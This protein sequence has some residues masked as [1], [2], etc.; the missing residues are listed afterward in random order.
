MTGSEE[1]VVARAHVANTRESSQ[2]NPLWQRKTILRLGCEHVSIEIRTCCIST[3]LVAGSVDA[4]L[5]ERRV[6]R[7]IADVPFGGE[8]LVLVQGHVFI[9]MQFVLLKRLFAAQS[10][11]VKVGGKFKLRS[12]GWEMKRDR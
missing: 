12:C 3:Q 8:N 7:H 5:I 9:K 11:R 10:L 6:A 1:F 4:F 2:A